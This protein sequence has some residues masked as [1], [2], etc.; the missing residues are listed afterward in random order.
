MTECTDILAQYENLR[1]KQKETLSTLL[2]PANEQ[3]KRLQA[4]KVE[5]NL[6]DKPDQL[7]QW[8]AEFR[9]KK[10]YQ[11]SIVS[12]MVEI[13]KQ[14]RQ[15]RPQIEGIKKIS[16]PSSDSSETKLPRKKRRSKKTTTLPYLIPLLSKVESEMTFFLEKN[17][18]SLT[19]EISSEI[20]AVHHNEL[21]ERLTQR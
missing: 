11:L 19:K 14:L 2:Y 12:Q 3:L 17:V 5:H 13:N 8:K 10:D 4:Y 18:F 20:R 7:K 1:R 15:I 16:L 6:K 9:Q 21:V